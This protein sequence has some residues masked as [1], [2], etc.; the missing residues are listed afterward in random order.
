M[1][2]SSHPAHAP[3][4]LHLLLSFPFFQHP[5]VMVSTVVLVGVLL[6]VYGLTFCCACTVLACFYIFRRKLVRPTFRRR[7]QPPVPP[8]APPPAG[9][10]L[11]MEPQPPQ[12]PRPRTWEET[13]VPIEDVYDDKVEPPHPGPGRPTSSEDPESAAVEEEIP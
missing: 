4:P 1:F 13:I 2:S 9:D 12:R 10:D 7:Q 8:A 3:D 11:P 6:G 5:L